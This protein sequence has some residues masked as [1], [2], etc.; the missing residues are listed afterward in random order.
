MTETNIQNTTVKQDLLDRLPEWCKKDL[1]PENYYLI[2]TDDADSILSCQ[3]LKTLFGLEIG[4]FYSF[5]KGLYINSEISDDGW[6]TPIFVDL[7]VSEGL[8]YDNHFSFIQNPQKANPN[9][10]NRPRYNQKFCG[11]TLMFLCGLYGGV[12][13]MNET[14][15]TVLLCVDGFYI[16]YYKDGGR[17][18]DVNLYWLDKLGLTEYLLPILENHDRQ[19]FKDFIKEYQL[20]EKVWIDADGYLHCAALGVPGIKF[21]LDTEIEKVFTD[22]RQAMRMYKDGVPIFVSASTYENSYVLNLEKAG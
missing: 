9:V 2:L 5:E 18:K 8:A 19:Y 17:W 10:M 20:E 21:E 1:S 7:S 3:R 13:Q 22:K 4:G 15:R 14:L 6:K 16:G 12:Q 11:S